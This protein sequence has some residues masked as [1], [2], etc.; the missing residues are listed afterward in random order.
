MP[1]LLTEAVLYFWP[2]GAPSCASHQ[3]TGVSLKIITIPPRSLGFLLC[4]VGTR[5][6][7]PEARRGNGSGLWQDLS[8][9]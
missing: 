3:K 1:S 7:K 9:N 2:Q 6:H 8:T 4:G 5:R